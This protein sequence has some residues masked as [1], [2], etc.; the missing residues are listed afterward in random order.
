[1]VIIPII[2][3]GVAPIRILNLKDIRPTTKRNKYRIP[4]PTMPI[5]TKIL[6]GCF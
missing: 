6:L 3:K 4:I 1:M 5:K 2:T